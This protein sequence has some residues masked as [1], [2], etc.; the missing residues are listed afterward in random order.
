MGK[1]VLL[2]YSRVPSFTNTVRDYVEAFGAHSV[3]RV[4]YYD[5]DSGPIHFDLTP[6]DCIIFNFCFWGRCL[7]VS[8]EFRARMR[9]FHG[10]KIAIFQDEYDYF[11]WH[12]QTVLDI[13]IDTIVTCV[14]EAYWP[15]V[16]PDEAFRKVELISALTGYVPD[17]L[18][19]ERPAR[20]LEERPW[21]IGYRSRKVPYYLSLIHI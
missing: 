9:G 14:P 4:H 18:S 20:P 3:H 15:Q 5:M 7:A 8:P 1:N 2:A 19:G 12:R 16:F 17:T 13:G 21:H 11:L 6:F 10:L